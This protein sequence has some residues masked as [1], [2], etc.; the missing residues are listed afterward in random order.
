MLRK[1]DDED[2]DAEGEQD[3][4]HPDLAMEDLNFQIARISIKLED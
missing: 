4:P 2:V 3:E 1:E